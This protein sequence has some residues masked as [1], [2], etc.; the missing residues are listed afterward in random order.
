MGNYRIDVLDGRRVIEIQHS[1]LASI[2]P[3]IKK[4]L[5]KHRVDVVK[6]IVARKKIVKL[7]KKGGVVKS[8]RWSP[9]RGSELDLFQEL[10]YFTSVFPHP[11]L[12]LRI[13]LVE[14]EETR[15]P[16]RRRWFRG[17][18][19][20]QDQSLVRV[21]SETSY[22]SRDDLIQL[23]PTSLGEPFGTLELSEEMAIKRWV[24]QKIAYCLR[25]TG[26]AQAVGKVG[27][28]VQY[29]LVR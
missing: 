13:P 23:L 27:N 8:R 6:P 29:R 22:R 1:S 12:T 20:V 16:H 7:D 10:I 11:R 26:C 24:A 18:F 19:K 15:Y 9:K 3:K 4:L 28:S 5:S 14:I 25:K 17:Q 21:V 2:R